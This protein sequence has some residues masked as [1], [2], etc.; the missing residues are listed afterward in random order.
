MNEIEKNISRGKHILILTPGFPKDEAD[1]NCIPPLQEFLK[2]FKSTHPIARISVIA[3]QYPYEKK[4]YKWNDIQ[5]HSLAG[6]N[7]KIKKVY[8]WFRAVRLAKK[9]HRAN[10]IDLI[11]SLWLGE[12]ALTGHFISKKFNCKHICT[13]MGQDV[14]SSNKYLRLLKNSSAKIIALSKNQAD[15]FFRL[16]GRIV[17]QII[18]WGIEDQVTN[19]TE[20][21]ID[22]FAAG[23]FIPLKN[24]SL[25]IRTVEQII[26]VRP[27][28]KCIL[29]G[30][31]PEESKLKS[32]V[33]EK[34]LEKNITF[35]GLL[36]R[37]EIFKLMQRSK[38]FVH[39]S[40]FEGSGYV[41]AEELANGMNI[42]SFNVGYAR[43]HPKWF[44]A[45]DEED[46]VTIIKKLL[47][48]ELDCNPVNLFPMEETVHEYGKIY[49]VV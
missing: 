10:N 24:Y 17:D 27:A 1:D 19:N 16:T 42:A 39:P 12:C 46:F 49:G 44:I 35:P 13:L 37:K 43:E 45:E 48:V 36:N 25:L 20:R 6:K 30:S 29:A 14:K 31:G 23:S 34:G 18:H 33:K 40:T 38:I 11:H 3:F 15:E 22:L 26:E 9:I 32:L 7:S 4:S 21:D 28:I 2:R 47:P 8:I 41:F 5:V